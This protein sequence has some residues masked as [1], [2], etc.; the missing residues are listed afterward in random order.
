MSNSFDATTNSQVFSVSG[1]GFTAGDLAGVSMYID[2]VE[3]ETLD[4][5]ST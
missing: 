3:Q 5:T 2:G 4:V 1:S